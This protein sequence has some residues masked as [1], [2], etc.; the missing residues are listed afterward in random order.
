MKKTLR[1]IVVLFLLVFLSSCGEL[2]LFE[3]VT[4]S[5][6]NTDLNDRVVYKNSNLSEPKLSSKEGYTFAGWYYDNEFNNE[7]ETFPLY[8]TEK[9]TLYAKWEIN[10][11][12]ITYKILEEEYTVEYFYNEEVV[13]PDD[14]V[15]ENLIFGGWLNE[16][17][18]IMP[19]ENLTIEALFHK[20]TNNLIF[21]VLGNETTE[22]YTYPNKPTKPNNPFV[23]GYLFKGWYLDEQYL[24]EYLFDDTLLEDLTIYAKFSKIYTIS[25]IVN[26]GTQIDDVLITEGE[27]VERLTNPT[28]EGYYFRGWYLD[29]NYLLKFRFGEEINSNLVLYAKFSLNNFIDEEELILDINDN[30]YTVGVYIDNDFVNSGFFYKKEETGSDYLYYGLTIMADSNL[31]LSGLSIT[32]P[33]DRLVHEINNYAL[34]EDYSLIVF[35]IVTNKEYSVINLSNREIIVGENVLS[36][37][38]PSL[39]FN[40]PTLRFGMISYIEEDYFM[41]DS[42]LNIG[43]LGSPIINYNNEV[44]G[45]FSSYTSYYDE[46][47]EEGDF[48]F[49]YG[50]NEAL[51]LT[52]FSEFIND[53]NLEELNELSLTSNEISSFES[54]SEQE[55][56][57]IST[58][59]EIKQSNVF[60]I[61]NNELISSASLVKKD[62]DFYY[63]VTAF[64]E[65]IIYNFSNIKIKVNDILYNA[66]N[67]YYDEEEKIIIISFET[68]DELSYLKVT[69]DDVS[70]GMS[71]IIGG[72]LNQE[73][74]HFFTKGI[75]GKKEIANDYFMIDGKVNYYQMGSGVFNLNGD[76]IGIMSSKDYYYERIEK[77]E[78]GEDK[79]VIFIVES[80]QMAY[81][82]S[83][84]KNVLNNIN[85]L[86]P[87]DSFILD[88]V[89]KTN[90]LST[91]DFELK[92]INLL[93]EL[94][95]YSVRVETDYGSG[96]G[97]IYNKEV[98]ENDEYLYYALTNHHVI[99]GVTDIKVKLYDNSVYVV[100]DYF[101]DSKIDIAV[102]RFKTS[103]ELPVINIKDFS[104]SYKA[105]E[106]E[107]V[108]AIGTPLN[109]DYFNL[110]T[111]GII[112]HVNN[113][114]REM[115]V[116]ISLNPGNSGGPL[117]NYQGEL[118][119]INTAKHTT[120]E[121]YLGVD[122]ARGASLSIDL[123]KIK[124][125]V[126]EIS[127]ESYIKIERRPMLGVTVT[128]VE[129]FPFDRFYV[130]DIDVT[131]GSYGILEINDELLKINGKNI[132][133][134]NV[135]SNELSKVDLGDTVTLLIRRFI[136]GQYKEIT[137]IIPII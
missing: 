22:S 42:Y 109:K 64:N 6:E 95:T 127:E 80:I 93:E 13:I 87:N 33:K 130:V 34:F 103:N 24:N 5:F 1:M 31:D 14:P 56:L 105:K 136:D 61:L 124:T 9:L 23:E 65:E 108:F 120:Y 72:S 63:V 74:K 27:I 77:D 85:T 99:D 104:S 45:I 132:T 41:I 96:S 118:I 89:I 55:T 50:L 53:L 44:I 129:A 46:L 15:N 36:V 116:D 29:E 113:D 32:S 43:D 66:L 67:Y 135:V 4:V 20:K 115:Y 121:S 48:I 51:N 88:E 125:L 54:F 101:S 83:N 79:I 137:V 37:G 102:L 111:K 69:A 81:K 18:S 106:G 122:H 117:F 71:V 57:Q 2:N 131:R 59:D 21:N 90:Y 123:S 112:S 19:A 58:I 52:V 70:V 128:T 47:S 28:K 134:L 82:A 92:E 26:G 12:T 76:L 126:T 133:S 40:Y 25:F 3:K 35:T 17:P 75:V 8:I 39:D 110:V 49:G 10:I 16:I 107:I 73:G 119:G 60:L 94:L 97:V 68:T 114:R 78:D 11:Y 62:N 38:I 84:L 98:L 7:V 30:D 91:I 86:T 100:L